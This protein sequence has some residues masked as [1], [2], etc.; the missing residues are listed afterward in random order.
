M[1][2]SLALIW[3]KVGLYCY[4]VS[5]KLLPVWH[6]RAQLK[7]LEQMQPSHPFIISQNILKPYEHSKKSNRRLHLCWNLHSTLSSGGSYALKIKCQCEVHCTKD[8]PSNSDEALNS[9]VVLT[10]QPS[11][12]FQRM[13]FMSIN[14]SPMCIANHL[15]DPLYFP[16]GTRWS[17]HFIISDVILW[18]HS[19]VVYKEKDHDKTERKNKTKQKPIE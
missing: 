17:K 1:K 14:L 9:N 10:L 11:P 18:D 13:E 4:L 7:G 3:L 8:L 12:H 16:H 5:N 19:T 6:Y 15:K 2:L